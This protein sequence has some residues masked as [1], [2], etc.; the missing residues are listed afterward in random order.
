MS[1]FD[2]YFYREINICRGVIILYKNLKL[3]FNKSSTQARSPLKVSMWQ[4]ILAFIGG[5]IT[6]FI[7]VS[8]SEGL[9]LSLLIAP[10]GASCVL[11][12]ALPEAAV[13]QPRNIIGGHFITA[14]CGLV[15]YHWLGNGIWAL[16]LAVGLGIALMI[17]TKTTH[18]PAGANPIVV[19]TAASSWSFLITPVLVGSI[20]VVCVALLYNNLIKHRKYPTFWL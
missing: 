14:L 11:A 20:V 1:H 19:I 5:F 3:Y 15:V 17:L 10:F 13:S 12:F 16:S 9:H 4:A 18:P 7:L 2:V 8:L 6:I